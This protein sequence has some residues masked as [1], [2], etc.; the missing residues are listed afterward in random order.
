MSE[1]KQTQSEPMQNVYHARNAR[2]LSERHQTLTG[3]VD[4]ALVIDQTNV[5]FQYRVQQLHVRFLRFD[6]VRKE[7]IGFLGN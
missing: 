2:I 5:L 3:L 4:N 6:G 1:R 7:A